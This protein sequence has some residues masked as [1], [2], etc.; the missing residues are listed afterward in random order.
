M[1]NPT[2]WHGTLGV[3]RL[4]KCHTRDSS[5]TI[6]LKCMTIRLLKNNIILRSV[7]RYEEIER[8]FQD[9]NCLKY[10]E[11]IQRIL[12]PPAFFIFFIFL[13][14]CHVSY[15]SSLPDQVT[16]CLLRKQTNVFVSRLYQYGKGTYNS[17]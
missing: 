17:I 16:Y 7:K 2:V 5:S 6:M 14:N 9:I 11:G 1:L 3:K 12:R 10:D 15:F 4:K 8:V 13:H